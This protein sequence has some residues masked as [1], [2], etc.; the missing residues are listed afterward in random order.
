MSETETY[1]KNCRSCSKEQ[2]EKINVQRFVEKLDGY[3][4]RNDIK[5]A[6]NHF[7]YW[8]REAKILKDN[9]GLLSILNEEIGFYRRT[10]DKENGIKAVNEAIT[11]IEENDFA[12][13]LSVATIYVN[14][15]TTM[16]AFDMADKSLSYF[17]FAEKIYLDNGKK[18]SYDYAALL[19]NKAAALCDL[20][21]F[22]EAENCYN[23]AIEI[24]KIEGNHD[25][26]IAISLVNMAQ[27]I[28]QRSAKAY[29]EIENTLDLAWEYINSTRQIRDW[30]YAFV[31]SKCAPSFRFFKR[32]EEANALEEVAKEIYGKGGQ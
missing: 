16:K 4:E 12:T 17:N 23:K 9:K 15:A 6:F 10:N 14:A 3:F 28:F 18:D 20:E 26:D 29:Q 31:L 24:L 5:G 21:M 19:N 1:I 8:E 27:L 2:V 11:I 13:N 7:Q 25:G 22:S 30:S 32:E